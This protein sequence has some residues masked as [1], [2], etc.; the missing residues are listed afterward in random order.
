MR[1]TIIE[2]AGAIVFKNT[3]A[4]PLI[5]IV[6]AKKDP[7]HWIFPKGHID[8]GETAED[9]GIRECAEEAG[10]VGR[11]VRRAGVEEFSM[12]DKMYRVTYFLVR[13]AS[14][15]GK[16]E[17][18]RQPRFCTIDDALSLLSFPASKEMLKNMRSWIVSA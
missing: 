8:P 3:E 15:S 12:A 10:V 9:A 17:T 7:S 18:A 1:N 16:G 4:G 5:L 6:R 14:V 2:Q 11:I 13:Y